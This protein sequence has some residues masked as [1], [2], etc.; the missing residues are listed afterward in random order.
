MKNV[1]FFLL[2]IIPLSLIFSNDIE[3]F[4]NL[5]I[6]TWNQKE[7]FLSQDKNLNSYS[8]G[9]DFFDENLGLSIE[10]SNINKD[11]LLIKL[12][13]QG[14]KAYINSIKSLNEYDFLAS[15]IYKR[16]QIENPSYIIIHIISENEIWLERYDHYRSRTNSNP[17]AGYTFSDF[18]FNFSIDRRGTSYPH[19]YRH[20]IDIN[21]GIISVNVK[22][23]YVRLRSEPNLNGEGKGFL[24]QGE[25]VQV[26]EISDHMDEFGDKIDNWYK[27]K[28]A[29]GT[30]AWT[31]GAFLDFPES[32]YVWYDGGTEG[33]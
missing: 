32:A 30:E 14:I 24:Q 27:V 20:Y 28:T 25:S 23:S 5:T 11:D 12:N 29:D 7:S 13:Y 1:F 15:V 6:G 17:I 16:D 2:L 3:P 9:S 18:D 31:F 10:I 4:I 33:K 22:S 26:I 8:W 21:R 19:F